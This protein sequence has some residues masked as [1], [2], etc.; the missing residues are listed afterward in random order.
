MLK[1][2]FLLNY[3]VCVIEYIRVLFVIL[4]CLPNRFMYDIW[5]VARANHN[6]HRARCVVIIIVL[7]AYLCPVYASLIHSLPTVEL[8]RSSKSSLKALI[9]DMSRAVFGI[10]VAFLFAAAA[11]ALRLEDIEGIFTV[12]FLCLTFVMFN[13]I[14]PSGHAFLPRNFPYICLVMR[15][16]T[17]SNI[18]YVQNAMLLLKTVKYSTSSYI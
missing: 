9:K 7:F 6:K 3:T 13:F 10:A 5:A 16:N 8:S 4:Q 14:C 18:L 17:E 15:R 2:N 12:H 11:S 1:T